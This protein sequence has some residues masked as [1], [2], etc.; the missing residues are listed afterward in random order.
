LVVFGSIVLFGLYLFALQRW[1][2]SAVSYVTLLMPLVTIP[3][4]AVLI[5][6]TV[7]VSFLA[8]GALAV[9]GVYVGAFLHVRPRRT[10]ASGLAECLPVENCGPAT[11]PGGVTPGSTGNA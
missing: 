1:T 9:I 7:S 10:S 4:A 3:V 8:G 5:S 11:S 2:A 6:E